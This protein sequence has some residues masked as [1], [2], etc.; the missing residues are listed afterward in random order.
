MNLRLLNK[1]VL[2]EP[3]NQKQSSLVEVVEKRKDTSV[4]YKVVGIAPLV[5][6]VKIG[7][8]IVLKMGDHTAPF[9]F[10]DVRVAITSEDRIQAVLNV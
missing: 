9:M 8:I 1:D 6:E 5:T 2:I 10:N 7:D 3:Y 4:T